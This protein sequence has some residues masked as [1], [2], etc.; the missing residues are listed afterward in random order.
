MEKKGG[1]CN[2]TKFRVEEN[3]VQTQ[4]KLKKKYKIPLK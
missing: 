4:Q 3:E 2:V 1:Y